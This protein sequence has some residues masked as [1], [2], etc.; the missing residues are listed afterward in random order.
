MVGKLVVRIEV[1]ILRF[2]VAGGFRQFNL[3]R[4]FNGSCF[5]AEIIIANWKIP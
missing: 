3:K 4:A 1:D 5:E 2:S